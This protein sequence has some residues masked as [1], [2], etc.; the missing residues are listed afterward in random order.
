MKPASCSRI[1][2]GRPDS[3]I[4]E[5]IGKAEALRAMQVRQRRFGVRELALALGFRRLA[6]VKEKF[7]D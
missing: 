5:R 2:A 1:D 3:V 4:C 7:N 6:A